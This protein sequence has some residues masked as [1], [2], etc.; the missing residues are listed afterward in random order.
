MLTKKH[1]AT[2]LI[3]GLFLAWFAVL[4]PAPI[5]GPATY[6]VIDGTSMEPTF[7]DGDLAIMRR[8]DAYRSGDVIA[9]RI[10]GTEAGG[11][12]IHR[13]VGGTA[14]EGFL[15]QGDSRTEQDPWRPKPEDIVG[16]L[17]F[18][19]P[20]AGSHLALL[21]NPLVIAP[22]AAGVTVFLVLLG[23][24]RAGRQDPEPG[25][26]DPEPGRTLAFSRVRRVRRRWEA[27]P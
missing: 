27:E 4:G 14:Q 12:V 2:L 8:A 24:G 7:I 6:V 1:A 25:R 20:G 5:G 9:F 19:L 17:W 18:S 21:R 26:Q 3:L 15:T 13:I 22:L 11:L 10:P 23:G 16:S